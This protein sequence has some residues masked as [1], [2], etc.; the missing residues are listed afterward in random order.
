MDSSHTRGVMMPL[1]TAFVIVLVAA[2]AWTLCRSESAEESFWGAPKGKS[3]SPTAA[4][5]GLSGVK[6]SEAPLDVSAKTMEYDRP[7]H[8]IHAMG[9]VVV[10]RDEMELRADRMTVNMLTHGIAA[11]GNV[12]FTR[13]ITPTPSRG[14]AGTATPTN[15]AAASPRQISEWRGDTLF[16]NYETREWRSGSFTSFFDPFYVRSASSSTANGEY[17]LE[18]G[19]MTTCTNDPSGCHYSIHCSQIRVRQGDRIAG[20]NAVVWLGPVPIFYVPYWYRSFDRSVGISADAGYR[21]SWGYFLDTTTKY[22]IAPDLRGATEVD[23]R[24][25]R[26]PGVGQEVGWIVTNGQGRVYGY[27]THD[28]EPNGDYNGENRTDVDPERYRLRFQHAQGLTDRDYILADINY[29]SDP[30]VVEDFFRTEYRGGFQPQNNLSLTHRG[31][32]FS[33]GVSLYKRLNDFYTAV[34][35][36]PEANLDVFRTRLGDSPFYYE[37]RNS[38]AFLQKLWAEDESDSRD[39]Y[40]AARIDSSHML[41]YPTRQFGFLN[42]IPRAGY[43]ATYYSETVTRM[44]TN[45]VTTLL[46]T[47]SIPGPGGSPTI[48]V[49]SETR[50]NDVTVVTPE[51]SGVRS[52]VELG[53]ETSFRAFK[54]LDAGETIFGTGLRHIVEP[55]ANYTFVPEPNLTPGRLYQFDTVDTLDKNDSVRFG[56]RNQL[57]TK[58]GERVIDLAD[59]DINTRYLF[60]DADGEPFDTLNLNAELNPA[61]HVTFFADSSYD[62]RKNQVTVFNSRLLA[63]R[64]PWRFHIEHRYRVN[65]SSLLIADLAWAANK[66]WEFGVYDRYE[67]EEARLEE[68]AFYVT[69]MLD[70]MGIKFACGYLPGATRDDGTTSKDEYRVSVQLWLTAFPNVK[71]GTTARD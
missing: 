42:V 26:G 1:R 69:R 45:Q 29:L 51:G 21:G 56:L 38:A 25:S 70:C 31:D 24:T 20:R 2:S 53:V 67:F 16:Y 65:D 22:W 47:N 34:D 9:D 54:V 64:D 27:Y 41:Y 48:M 66:Q 35:R 15:A 44:T 28:E 58:I 4:F 14:G 17:L 71:V 7:A 68:Q 57:Q 8:L 59:V 12:V 62:F 33:A 3:K 40:S 39:D 43:R 52:L 37:S 32:A 5:S 63:G 19:T 13:T 49:T 10:R 6:T 46:V 36:L 30:Y 11:T 23:Y 61:R 55:Y 60:E 50:T 18:N